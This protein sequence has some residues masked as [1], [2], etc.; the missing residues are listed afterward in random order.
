MADEPS[1]ATPR[2]QAA[3]INPD[4]ALTWFLSIVGVGVAINLLSSAVER[5]RWAWLPPTLFTLAV[6]TVLPRTGLL[7]REPHA[8]TRW[9]RGVAVASL[10]AYL[11]VAIWGATTAWPLAVMILST[12]CLWATCVLV[13]WPSLRSQQNLEI[14][15]VAVAALGVGVAV[16]IVGVTWMRDGEILGGIAT[17]LFGVASLLVGIAWLRDHLALLGAAAVLVGV[18]SLLVGVEALRDGDTLA[19]VGMLVVGVSWVLFAIVALR[20]GDT[21]Y[22]VALLLLA[23][24]VMLFG[25]A[26][27]HHPN[28]SGRAAVT[29]IKAWLTQR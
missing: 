3:G 11:G 23:V 5:Y 1:R 29:R 6:L 20:D 10:L 27:L 4:R 13:T 12:A 16:L 26:G 25:L 14:V 9:T 8:G 24:A 22:G 17:V 21:L 18:M 28:Q 19:G 15:A 7:R 2:S